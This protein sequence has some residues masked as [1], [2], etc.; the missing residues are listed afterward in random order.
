MPPPSGEQVVLV[1]GDLEAVITEVGAT[2]RSFTAG[3]V[4][5]IWGFSEEEISSGDRGHVLAPW[6]NR[7]EDGSFRFGDRAGQ[8]P[9]N[10]PERS[11]AIHGLVRWLPWSIERV[12]QDR[13][14][15]SCVIHPQP[16]YPFRIR[17]AL[18]YA[19]GDGGLEVMC[20]VVNPGTGG[21]PF[22]LGFHPY[23]LGGP[24]GIDEAQIRLSAQRRLLLDKRGL[25][26]GEEQ[27][28]AGTAFELERRLLK[29]LELDDCYT[30]LALGVDGRW[31]ASLDL[32]GRRSEIWADPAF[33]YVMC[34]TG[35]TLGEPGDRRKAI[36][37]E[38]MTCPPNSLR[39]G[40]SL[41]ELREGERWSASWGIATV[42]A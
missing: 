27:L 33:A 4:P 7:L 25:P 42:S 9:L 38:P 28:V 36:A 24:N 41:I 20:E 37:I 3:S 30:G 10:E 32:P 19:L 31:H 34:Y 6:P 11:N 40:T 23:L 18:E 17:L 15:L 13:A 12:S 35:D 5:V 1:H 22:G 26:T 8:V 2:L 14:V 16:A 39:T 29:G 21:A